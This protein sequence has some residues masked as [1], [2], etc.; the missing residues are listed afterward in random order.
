MRPGRPGRTGR[1]RLASSSVRPSSSRSSSWPGVTA[2][3]GWSGWSLDAVSP[4][5]PGLA[6][7][8]LTPALAAWTSVTSWSLVAALALFASWASH[9]HPTELSHL[10]GQSCNVSSRIVAG[11]LHIPHDAHGDQHHEQEGGELL[12]LHLLLQSSTDRGGILLRR[13]RSN[14]S[15]FS[16]SSARRSGVEPK[17]RPRAATSRYT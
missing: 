7:P 17:V 13:S 12:A 16:R 1:S 2:S 5:L 14:W 9:R 10:L 4:V 11:I 15:S 8:T 3:S 6:W